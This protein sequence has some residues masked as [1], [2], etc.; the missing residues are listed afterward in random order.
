MNTLIPKPTGDTIASHVQSEIERLALH[1]VLHAQ[2]IAAKR[3]VRLQFLDTEEAFDY[4]I[5]SRLIGQI[6][7]HLEGFAR[8]RKLTH[9]GDE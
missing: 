1:D 3:L 5:E 9:A 7:K 6:Q 2:Y 4:P 8:Y